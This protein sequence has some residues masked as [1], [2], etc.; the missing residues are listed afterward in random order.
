MKRILKGIAF[1]M[2]RLPL[3]TALAVGRGLGWIYGSVVRYHRRD[4]LEALKRSFPEKSD[5]EIRDLARR[6]YAN[7]GM[8]LMELFRLADPR[9]GYPGSLVETEG[10]EHMAAAQARGKGVIVLSAHVGN[11]DLLCTAAP[12]WGYPLTIITK[13]IKNKAL[14]ELWMEIRS[15]YGL[16]FVPAHNSYRACLSA[17]RKNEIVGFVLDQN[18]IDKEGIFVDF[19]GKPACTSPGLAYMSAQSG[20]PVV[21]SFMVRK[22]K[23]RHLVK[24]LPLIEPPP[25]RKPETI[26]DYTQRYTK[27]IEDVV[28]EYPDQWIW[29]HRRWKT[30]PPRARDC[31]S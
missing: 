10:A 13:V 15:R 18:M 1:A 30:Q 29:L 20:A 17:L 8:N 22:P 4:A 7:L 21:P 6:M 2:G 26:R 14:N 28:R 25:D 5:S 3:P 9:S 11:W 27:V 19:F 24:F 16:K 23:G 31:V 12:T